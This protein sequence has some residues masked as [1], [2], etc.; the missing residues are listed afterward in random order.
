MIFRLEEASSCT[1]TTIITTTKQ[2]HHVRCTSHRSRAARNLYP[3]RPRALSLCEA[4]ALKKPILCFLWRCS[5]GTNCTLYIV[6]GACMV[7]KPFSVRLASESMPAASR[8]KK[9]QRQLQLSILS[10]S[11]SLPSAA[12]RN[13][14]RLTTGEQGCCAGS[15]L[16]THGTVPATCMAFH[17][18]DKLSTPK[19]T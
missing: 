11:S 7:R 12:L 6:G 18:L 2:R 13:A 10:T 8:P 1:T 9:L 19:G 14:R 17:V 4:A 16:R 5:D 15:H 3:I